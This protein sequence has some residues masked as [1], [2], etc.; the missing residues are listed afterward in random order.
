MAEIVTDLV[1]GLGGLW[2][3]ITTNLIPA[4]AASLNFLHI[5]IWGSPVIGLIS[6]L[7]NKVVRRR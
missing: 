3:F 6:L 2:G 4:D 1:A 7:F 5:M